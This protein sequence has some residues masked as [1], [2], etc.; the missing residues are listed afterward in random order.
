[1]ASILDQILQSKLREVTHRMEQRPMKTLVS[2]AYFTQAPR[3]ASTAILAHKHGA[4]IAEFK[5]KSPSKGWLRGDACPKTISEKYQHAGAAVI[6]V[7]TDETFF[8]AKA[9]D[10]Q[11]VRDT[12]DV[13]LLRKDFIIHPYQIY[14][15]KSMGADLILL[16]AKVLTKEKLME[17]TM[18][19]EDLGLETMVEFESEEEID[20]LRGYVPTLCGINNRNLENFEVQFEKSIE[21]GGLLPNAALKI[22]ESGINH[23]KDA[24]QLHHHGFQ[25]FLIGEYFMTADDPGIQCHDFLHDLRDLINLRA[26]SFTQ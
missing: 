23:A 24:A 6:S 18:R 21:I 1:M 13:P 16:I 15:S 14:E 25:G 5:R 9:D 26:Q 4:V 17:F 2:S 22:A 12:V 10:F 7:L 20:L 19:A 3:S 11:Q 8:G